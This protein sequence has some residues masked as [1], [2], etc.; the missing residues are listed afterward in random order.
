MT[1][2]KNS[3]I[4]D[5]SPLNGLKGDTMN[6]SRWN[7]ARKCRVWAYRNLYVDEFD[8]KVVERGTNVFALCGQL[9]HIRLYVL[10]VRVQH[11]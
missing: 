11:V 7:S 6:L 9:S 2:L 3:K 8:R 10:H 1:T 4:W 5:F